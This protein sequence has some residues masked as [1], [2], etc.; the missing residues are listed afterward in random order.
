MAFRRIGE[1]A[2]ERWSRWLLVGCPLMERKSTWAAARAELIAS[3][4]MLAGWE[5]RQVAILIVRNVY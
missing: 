5:M 2:F 1:M 3:E 4:L